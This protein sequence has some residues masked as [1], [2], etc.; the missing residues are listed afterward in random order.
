MYC[1][2]CLSVDEFWLYQTGTEINTCPLAQVGVKTSWA[3][4]NCRFSVSFLKVTHPMVSA[5][6]IKFP[7][8]SDQVTI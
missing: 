7:T 2:L 6:K 4:T 3:S 8:L 1:K 5:V